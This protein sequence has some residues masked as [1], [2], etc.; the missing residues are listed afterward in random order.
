[1]DIYLIYRIYLVCLIS[2]DVFKE[3]ATKNHIAIG[4]ITGSTCGN[5]SEE[6]LEEQRM[7]MIGNVDDVGF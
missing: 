6:E 2:I 5:Q 1:M 3:A 4:H 7:P